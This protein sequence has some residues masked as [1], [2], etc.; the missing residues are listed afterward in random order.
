MLGNKDQIKEL[1]LVQA[2]DFRAMDIGV[3]REDLAFVAK[4]LKSPFIFLATGLRRIGKSTLFAQIARKFYQEGDYYYVNF[5]HYAFLDF[6]AQDFRDLSEILIELFGE[7]KIYFFDEIQNIEAWESFARALFDAGNKVYITGSNSSLFSREFATRLTG[8]NIG[9][10]VFPFSFK[11]F[12][13]FN[14]IS[15]AKHH[16]IYDTRTRVLLKKQF[17]QYME[18]GGIAQCLRYPELDM[19]KTIYENSIYKDIVARYNIDSDKAIRDLGYYLLGNIAA[20]LSYTKLKSHLAVKNVTT[21]ANYIDYFEQVWLFF[22][23]NQF[24]ASIKKQQVAPKKIYSIDSGLT[25]A[26]AFSVSEKRGA[27]LENIVFLYLRKR[28]QEIYYYKTVKGYEVDFYVPSSSAL[29]QVSYD[30]SDLETRERELRALAQAKEELAAKELYIISF[31]T[32]E[33]IKLGRSLVRV[34]PAYE[35]FLD[36]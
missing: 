19:H 5:D 35:F 18:L 32:K 33:D 12:L 1:L 7:R 29:Y 25:K 21:V 22:E 10:E 36:S 15:Y 9:L 28:H 6:K 30:L 23:I 20:P 27:I 17:K 13:D 14:D 31:D 24:S 3:A 16:G 11:E 4:Q 2:D 8:R 34:I 26:L